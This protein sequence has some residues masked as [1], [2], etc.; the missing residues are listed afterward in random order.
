MER[1]TVYYQGRVQGVGFRQTA[2][3]IA[4]SHA[5]GGYVQNVPNGQVELVVEGT[6]EA[7]D[8]FLAAIARRMGS[9]IS[10]ARTEQSLA[11]GEFDVFDVRY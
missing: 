6:N 10:Q 5:V 1:R 4:Q 7:M 3:S 9:Y 8:R 11:T 2:I